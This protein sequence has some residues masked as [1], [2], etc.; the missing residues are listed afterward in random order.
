RRNPPRTLHPGEAQG[1]TS[2]RCVLAL[3]LPACLALAA[4]WPQWRGP[5]RDGTLP[6]VTFPDKLPEKLPVKWRLPLGG[7]YG[8]IAVTQGRVYVMDRQK[9]PREVER[10]LCLDAATGK[11]RWT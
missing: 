10:V 5:A 9:A 7:G 8:G 11:V 6:G 4:D 3:F 1:M 2:S